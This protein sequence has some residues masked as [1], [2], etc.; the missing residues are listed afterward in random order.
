VLHLVHGLAYADGSGLVKDDFDS[1]E[2]AAHGG[3]VANIR[4]LELGLAV[5]V[6]GAPRIGSV[7]L[8][9]EVVQNADLVAVPKQGVDKM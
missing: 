2:G 4:H 9:V 6:F 5:Q 8:G 3:M 1:L 7:N